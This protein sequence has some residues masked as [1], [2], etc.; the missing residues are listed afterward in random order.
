MC[1]LVFSVDSGWLWCF[2]WFWCC[3]CLLL[4]LEFVVV[5]VATL[6][7]NSVVHFSYYVWFGVDCGYMFG[8]LMIWFHLVLVC[9][10][11]VVLL[12][13]DFGWLCLVD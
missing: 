3:R 4:F 12:R 1:L 7:L 8:V 6:I 11:G 9:L 5:I 2:C 13:V 10:S